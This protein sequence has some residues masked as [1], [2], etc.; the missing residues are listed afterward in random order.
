MIKKITKISLIIFLILILIIFYLSIFGIKTNKFNS[1]ISDNILKINKKINLNL[2][3]VNYLLNPYNF[4]INIKTKNPEILLEGRSLG[5]QDIQTNI[6]LNS[7]IN[8]EFLIDDLLITTKAIKIKDIIALVRLFQNTPK[9]FVLNTIVK[10]GIVNANINLNFDK[11]GN[12]KENYKIIGSV[13]KV[14]L[15]ML[16]QAKLKNLNFNFNIS[17]NFYSL[18]QIDMKFNDIKITSPL[19]DIKKNKDSFFVKGYLLNDKKEFDIE[20]LRPFLRSLSNNI[21]VQKIKFSSKNNFSFNISESLKFSNFKVDSTIDL[22]QLIIN[23]A[24]WMR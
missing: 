19:I 21:D 1:Q 14:K 7:L 6:A 8:D 3:E 9:L 15:N 10:D 11:K 20:E 22:N 4:T 24:S 17:K 23:Q 16:N 13:K 18:K 12:I 5:I 2:K